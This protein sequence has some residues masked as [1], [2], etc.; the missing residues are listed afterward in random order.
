MKKIISILLLTVSLFTLNS[1]KENDTI[2]DINYV[3]FEKEVYEFGVELT[4]STTNEIKVFTS[5]VSSSDRT[6]KIKVSE[7][8]TLDAGSYTLAT[9]VTVPAGANVGTFSLKIDDVNIESNDKV[10]ILE[11]VPEDADFYYGEKMTI[12]VKQVCPYNDVALAINFDGYASESSYELKDNN[13]AVVATSPSGWADGL[14]EFAT[15][16]CLQDGTYTFT[17]NDVYGDGLSYPSNGDIALTLNGTVLVSI[18]GDFGF[19]KTVTF[20]VPN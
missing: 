11:F 9:T 15:N 3:S 13:G 4:A 17:M 1:C 16:F 14:A 7:D 2:S 12:N 19:S 20:T 8:S 10:L 6:F 18:V 5:T